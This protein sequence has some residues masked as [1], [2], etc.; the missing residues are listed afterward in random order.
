[1]RFR[2]VALAISALTL[3]GFGPGAAAEQKP[4]ASPPA[5]GAAPVIV[6]K[7]PT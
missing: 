1:M 7:S 6:Y 2:H 3:A 5:P 4:A